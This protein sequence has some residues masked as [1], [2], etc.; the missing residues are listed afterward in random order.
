MSNPKKIVF[1]TPIAE[2]TFHEEDMFLFV[3]LT[4]KQVT[5]LKDVV[6][7]Y[8]I[9][10]QH[11]GEHLP[12]PILMDIRKM[13]SLSKEIRAYSATDEFVLSQVKYAAMIV[14]SG[15]PRVVGNFFLKLNKPPFP[16][17]LFTD[18]DKA[19]QWLLNQEK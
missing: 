14:N 13:K 8:E 7:H 5:E 15:I 4:D 12:L 10:H 6:K 11:V 17:R 16:T 3:T 1:N 18:F 9:V 19:K 2:V